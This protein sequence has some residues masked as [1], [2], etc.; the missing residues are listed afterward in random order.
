MG[1]PPGPRSWGP[2][3]A[4][5][6]QW[7]KREKE[8]PVSQRNRLFVIWSSTYTRAP[9]VTALMDPRLPSFP[10][11]GRASGTPSPVQQRTNGTSK[12]QTSPCSSDLVGTGTC[13][14]SSAGC[15]QASRLTCRHSCR[16]ACCRKLPLG[17]PQW[18]APS[19]L[20]LQQWSRP[21]CRRCI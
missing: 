10:T 17:V 2:V 15:H 16:Q 7:G 4:A 6:D 8:A 5:A 19:L 13:P 14:L 3:E 9:G 18:N 20:A 1:A 21:R 12:G 11:N